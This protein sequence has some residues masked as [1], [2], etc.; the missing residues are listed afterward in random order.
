MGR[1]AS[2]SAGLRRLIVERVADCFAGSPSGCKV[3]RH[4]RSRKGE[5]VRLTLDADRAVVTGRTSKQRGAAGAVAVADRVAALLWDRAVRPVRLG[6]PSIE[7]DGRDS[8][9]FRIVVTARFRPDVA[10]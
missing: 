1:S 4:T 9:C 5:G 2:A 3:R 10:R 8:S 6:A 7:I